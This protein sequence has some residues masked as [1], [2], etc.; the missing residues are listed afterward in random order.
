MRISIN[1]AMPAVFMTVAVVLIGVCV[2]EPKL[3]ESQ[4]V[5]GTITA[6]ISSASALTNAGK[7]NHEPQLPPVYPPSDTPFNSNTYHD[8]Y[9]RNNDNY[10]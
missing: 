3:L 4:V 7:N 10:R 6:C 5:S 8:D 1:D 2:R 9:P